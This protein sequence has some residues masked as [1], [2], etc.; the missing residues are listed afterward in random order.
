MSRVAEKSSL[1]WN[2]NWAA[3]NGSKSLAERRTA[4]MALGIVQALRHKRITIDQGWDEFFNFETY[5][6]IRKQRFDRR[7]L[8]MFV[9][10]MELPNVEPLGDEALAKSYDAIE[11]LAEAIL[12]DRRPQIQKVSRVRDLTKR[13]GL[14]RK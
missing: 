13:R 3:S 8:D 4:V 9:C 14:G 10:A 2:R 7:L 11:H 12:K 6:H 5:M 1:L